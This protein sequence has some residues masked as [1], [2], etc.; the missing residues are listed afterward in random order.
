MIALD[1][2]RESYGVFV[3]STPLLEAGSSNL[4]WGECLQSRQHLL[5]TGGPNS[6]MVVPLPFLPP[7]LHYL[8]S[9]ENG[10]PWHWYEDHAGTLPT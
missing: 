3:G 7:V 1:C 4:I 2:Y 9:D 10:L 8:G 6:S 5:C